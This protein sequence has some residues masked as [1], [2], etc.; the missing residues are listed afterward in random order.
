MFV[1]CS[2]AVAPEMVNGRVEHGGNQPK[3]PL[4]QA[5]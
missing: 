5:P 1:G 4:P 3:N 2:V